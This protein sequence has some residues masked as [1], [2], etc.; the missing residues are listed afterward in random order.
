MSTYIIKH[1]P[2][3]G[4]GEIGIWA[5]FVEGEQ[6]AVTFCYTEQQAYRVLAALLLWDQ[7]AREIPKVMESFQFKLR[8]GA[9]GEEQK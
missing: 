5:I 8:I 4:A 1:S 6:Q 3:R 9:Q 7:A 2:A